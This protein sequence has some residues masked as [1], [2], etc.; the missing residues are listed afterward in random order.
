MKLLFDSQLLDHAKRFFFMFQILKTRNGNVNI[1]NFVADDS[2]ADERTIYR[3]HLEFQSITT[4]YVGRYYCVY[5]NSIKHES[6]SNFDAEVERFKASSIYVFV[7]GEWP[8]EV[9]S[10]RLKLRLNLC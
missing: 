1:I 5:N 2:T 7:D 9:L 3:S 8:D 6:D 10:E 4:E